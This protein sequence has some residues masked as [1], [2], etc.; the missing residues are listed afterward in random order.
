MICVIA[1]NFVGTVIGVLRSSIRRRTHK[2]RGLTYT[3]SEL[4]IIIA[5]Y[6]IL[7]P[8]RL[9]HTCIADRVNV[10]TS[11]SLTGRPTV[12]GGALDAGMLGI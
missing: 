10:S 7:L 4:A 12:N 5:S 6:I 11:N 2:Q 9:I 1:A 3:V 8:C